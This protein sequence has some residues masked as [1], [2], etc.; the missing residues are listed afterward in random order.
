MKGINDFRI[1]VSD[2]PIYE[3]GALSFSKYQPVYYTGIEPGTYTANGI[4]EGVTGP[5]STGYYYCKLNLPSGVNL[6]YNRPD[7]ERGDYFWTQDWQYTPTYGSSTS[8]SSNLYSIYFGQN[9]LSNI[10]KNENSLTSTSQLKFDGISDIEA[11][12]I[13]HFYQNNALT[14]SSNDKE[15]LKPI[16]IYLGPPFTRRC[17]SYISNIDYQ[18]VYENVNNLTVNVESPFLSLTDWNGKL[19][20][21]TTYQNF[22]NDIIY[23]KHNYVFETE[24]TIEERGTWYATGINVLESPATPQLSDSWTKDFYFRPDSSNGIS[25]RPRSFRNEQDRFYLMQKD[26]DNP[27]LLVLDMTFSKR[28]DREAK[29]ILHFLEEKNG[30][31][32]FKFDGVPNMT[33]SKNFFCPEWSHTYTFR[34][35]N[36][37]SATFVEVLYGPPV[38]TIFST[39]LFPDSSGIDFGYVPSGFSVSKEVTV[40]NSGSDDITYIVQPVKI[41]VD[42][43]SDENIDIFIE[44]KSQVDGVTIAPFDSGVINY[45]FYVTDTVSSDFDVTG[46]LNYKGQ[47]N[48]ME[49]A[50]ENGEKKQAPVVVNLTGRHDTSTSINATSNLPAGTGPASNSWLGW[51]KY[52][53]MSPGYNRATNSVKGI[54]SWRPPETGYFYEQFSVDISEYSNFAS[55]TSKTVDVERFPDGIIGGGIYGNLS[56]LSPKYTTEIENLSLETTY[57]VRVRGENN[58]YSA[59]SYYTYG[60]GVWDQNENIENNE[61][62]S[63]YISSPIPIYWGKV[64]DYIPIPNREIYNID[65][66]KEIEEKGM[67]SSNFSLYGG[68]NIVFGPLSKIGSKGEDSSFTGAL[69]ITGDYSAMES[70]LTITLNDCQVYGYGGA[71]CS[72][73]GTAMYV[74]AEG[75]IK[76]VVNNNTIIGGGGG[77]GCSLDVDDVTG[78]I[79]DE[80]DRKYNVL[81]NDVRESFFDVEG[82]NRYVYGGYGAGFDNK[83][84]IAQ[85]GKVFVS[86]ADTINGSE[87]YTL[88]VNSHLEEQAYVVEGSDTE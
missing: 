3:T 16:D 28:T 35:N 45:T 60:S 11:K 71:P 13:M 8:F 55:P 23:Y 73:G 75:D 47:N 63:G 22:K 20:P 70:G 57:Y 34:D 6:F 41:L 27:N 15:G 17:P 30:I 38:N 18:Y 54:F 37:I 80:E 68:I 10:S 50:P 83:K 88:I 78:V 53:V 43:K 4:T 66:Y 74:R 72:D 21:N 58:T 42:E 86:S 64:Y 9:Y 51:N 14:E 79:V 2:V 7:S 31:D 84:E 40:Y 5:F 12:S 48:I 46:P 52:A 36:D 29:A 33:G 87:G 1:K 61:V 82:T 56:G 24:G 44:N 69:I 49:F 39:K 32:V 81:R 76:F 59:S 62:L 26:G 65:V 77:G 85:N 25:F 67:F 19:I